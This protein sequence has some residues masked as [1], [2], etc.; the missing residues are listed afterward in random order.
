[1]PALRLSHKLFLAFALLTLV[2]ALWDWAGRREE[3]PPSAPG[4]TS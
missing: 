3:E 2:M 1:M 4:P